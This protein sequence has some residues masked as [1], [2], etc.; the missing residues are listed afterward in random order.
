MKTKFKKRLQEFLQ[1][2]HPE[3]MLL[4]AERGTLP[5]YLEDRVSLISP[6][7]DEL[8]EQGEDEAQIVALCIAEI[9][10]PLGPSKYQYLKAVLQEEFPK[11]FQQ[12]EDA[13]VL[14]FE[15]TKMIL[16]CLPAFEA[17]DF[18][19]EKLDDH[20]MR[21]MIIAELHDYLLSHP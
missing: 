10:K 11:E 1:E 5:Q 9:A 2:N 4:F 6:L 20:F 14:K 17:F 3:L 13:G 15:L 21:H 7:M 8:M 16:V 18:S 19:L 12:Y